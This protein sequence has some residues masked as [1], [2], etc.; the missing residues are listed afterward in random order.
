MLPA[1]L[2]ASVRSAPA[3]IQSSHLCLSPPSSGAEVPNRIKL[4]QCAQ[5]VML[6]PFG[7]QGP[8]LSRVWQR[9]GEPGRHRTPVAKVD[10]RS[11]VAK[12]E[13]QPTAT[14][15][16]PAGHREKPAGLG[17]ALGHV[18]PASLL[19]PLSAPSKNSRG[20]HLPSA[21]SPVIPPSVPVSAKPPPP[22]PA[23]RH[24]VTL[25][26]PFWSHH[27]HAGD[28]SKGRFPCARSHNGHAST[29]H[30]PVLS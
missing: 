18:A 23:P 1:P 26:S 24:P 30:C 15:P 6:S 9:P 21:L 22:S 28:L 11:Q 7:E 3:G 5:R 8:F 2:P 17:Q 4:G 16:A 13:E 29:C 20:C 12:I 27:H 10:I 14:V 25:F 19:I